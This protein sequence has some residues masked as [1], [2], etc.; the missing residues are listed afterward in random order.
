[1]TTDEMYDFAIDRG[2]VLYK[3]HIPAAVSITID[4]GI[5]NIA[6]DKSLTQSEE[7]V[8]LAHELGH[9]ETGSFYR[10]GIPGQCRAQLENRANKWAY[11]ELLP[12]MEIR[13]AY[14]AGIIENWDLA[15]HFGVTE[16][17]VVAALEYYTERCGID[18][19]DVGDEW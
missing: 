11:A 17:F 15:E 9:C 18:F 6:I 12:E 2:C 4:T 1:M 8:A 5:L 14:A 10:R 7:R 3:A 19:N 13:A 16:E